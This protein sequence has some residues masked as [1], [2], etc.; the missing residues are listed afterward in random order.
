MRVIVVG[1]GVAG[2]TAAGTARRAGAEVVVLEARERIGGRTWTA[3]LGP[4][5]IDLGAAWVHGPVGTRWPR[6]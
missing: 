4:G 5:A 2:L 6:L 1:A 3:P